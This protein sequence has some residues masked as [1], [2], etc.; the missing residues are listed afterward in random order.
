LTE[1]AQPGTKPIHHPDTRFAELPANG[2]GPNSPPV[3]QPQISS[4][5]A[6]WLSSSLSD[7]EYAAGVA[8]GLS[9]KP[10][11]PSKE[12]FLEQGGYFLLCDSRSAYW[13]R[14]EHRRW[15]Q[16]ILNP[17][18]L[19]Q[20]LIASIRHLWVP[21]ASV[22]PSWCHSMEACDQLNPLAAE[23]AS[24]DRLHR[25]VLRLAYHEQHPEFPMLA[26][27]MKSIL[28]AD[29]IGLETLELDYASWSAGDARTDLWL[30]TVNFPV[31]EFWNVGAWLLGTP[32]LRH[33]IAGGD[34]TR[35]AQW[36]QDWRNESLSSEQL[37]WQIIGSGWLQPLFHHWMRLKGPEQAKGIHLNNLGWFDFKSTW[38]EP[39]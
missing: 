29:N 23:P 6:T 14:I 30:G 39:E 2:L 21:A 34:V 4:D 37:T 15:I 38:L 16:Q 25:P 9:G 36:Q 31:P 10:S 1:P 26:R 35:L 22:L 33:S 11:D 5:T 24:S 19:A 18:L 27:A 12:M 32:L 28:A 17:Y 3:R 20:Q 8:A 13:T 7:V